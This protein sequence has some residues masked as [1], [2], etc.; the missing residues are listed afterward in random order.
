MTSIIPLELLGVNA[1]KAPEAVRN[2]I[3]KATILLNDGENPIIIYKMQG[4]KYL[5]SFYDIGATHRGDPIGRHSP[6]HRNS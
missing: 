5:R 1:S 3:E 6:V 4:N 2:R